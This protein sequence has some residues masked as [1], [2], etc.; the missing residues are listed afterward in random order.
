MHASRL[1]V[2]LL[3]GLCCC[4]AC[5]PSALH[6]KTHCAGLF[7]Q[8]SLQHALLCSASNVSQSLANSDQAAAVTA[9]M[10]SKPPL[11]HT[12][13]WLIQQGHVLHVAGVTAQ[14]LCS[15]GQDFPAASTSHRPLQG[16]KL[17]AYACWVVC[18]RQPCWSP[19][20]CSCS[21]LH[22]AAPLHMAA[23]HIA[24][25]MGVLGSGRRL[26]ECCLKFTWWHR[27]HAQG[28]RGL[29]RVVFEPQQS[30]AAWQARHQQC[31]CNRLILI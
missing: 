20:A 3:H 27:P 8:P 16:A 10:H 9:N 22:S 11:F 31:A 28:G 26:G 24:L 5:G 19:T 6:A 29:K 13:C 21:Y 4:A 17:W 1:C 15:A 23:S 7:L 25:C 14:Q 18:C 12:S 2:V 30:A